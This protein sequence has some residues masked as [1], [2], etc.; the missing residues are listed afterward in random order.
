MGIYPHEEWAKGSVVK[1]DGSQ[2]ETVVNYYDTMTGLTRIRVF[3]C[4]TEF[5][6][7]TNCYCCSCGE[8]EGSDPACRNHGWAATRPCE[9]HG[10][11]GQEWDDTLETAAGRMPESVQA[12]RRKH[13][14]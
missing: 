9:R 10:M 5:S 1:P 3:E 14:Q 6:V 13:E 4:I 7:R 2:V 12:Y 11:P 8:R